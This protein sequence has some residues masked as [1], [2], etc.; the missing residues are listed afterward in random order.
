MVLHSEEAPMQWEKAIVIPI[1]KKSSKNMSNLKR[2]LFN[3]NWCKG[4]QSCHTQ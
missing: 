3:V 2:N 4:L 1:P